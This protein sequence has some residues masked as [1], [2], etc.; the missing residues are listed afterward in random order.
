MPSTRLK[1]D[2]VRSRSFSR[3]ALSI[4]CIVVVAFNGT[5]ATG[6]AKPRP[7]E[8]W[9]AYPLDPQQQPT[10][11]PASSSASRPV[12]TTTRVAESPPAAKSVDT[13]LREIAALA[14]VALLATGVVVLRFSRHRSLAGAAEASDAI[15]R[16]AAV[17]PTTPPKRRLPMRF[18]DQDG[19]ETVEMAPSEDAADT[20]AK[21]PEPGAAK[22]GARRAGKRAA[23]VSA[24][25]ADEAA[26]R[27]PGAAIPAGPAPATPA[28]GQ[29]PRKVAADAREPPR[30][31]ERPPLGPEER[32]EAADAKS[33]AEPQPEAKPGRPTPVPPRTPERRPSG[34]EE[35]REAAEAEAEPS[36][37]PKPDRSTSAA[38]GSGERG[39][40]RADP[41]PGLT[42]EPRNGP[43]FRAGT[44]GEPE[45]P[46]RDAG[47]TAPAAP[48]RPLQRCAIVLRR[49]GATARFEVVAVEGHSRNGPPTARSPSFVISPAGA[50]SNDR[51]ARTAHDALVTQL[52]AVGWRR[53]ESRGD[54][55]EA[56][57]LRD[58][59]D[60]GANSVDHATVVCR[61]LGRE[62]RF[63]A[64][65][66]DDYGNAMR[67]AASP[68]F[69]V[70][71]RGSVRP[72]SEARALHDA[73]VRYLQRLGWE[74]DQP[75]VGEWFSASL[76]R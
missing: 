42:A 28:S 40:S 54:W 74:T 30:P 7:Q 58:L 57:F 56:V 64:V 9:K 61:R 31:P 71:R 69:S 51:R 43:R 2:P 66:L 39:A 14:L 34:L 68:P 70:R 8:L 65:Q 45:A 36:R 1:A 50:V 53:E 67:L 60:E 75:S 52:S 62:A 25:A 4:L 23:A 41:S 76:R 59:A 6:A 63:E 21:T 35:W 19:N 48:A 49:S 11:A 15:A 3:R 16:A 73:L 72:T 32:R 38:Q 10:P 55:Y 29:R 46:E 44:E 26:R 12:A 17:S 20:E 33:R 37:K 22:N 47:A 13:N 27:E 24:R 5:A 18:F